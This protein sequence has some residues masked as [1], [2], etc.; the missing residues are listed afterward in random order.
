[1]RMGR[2]GTTIEQ[3]VIASEARQSSSVRWFW[4][5]R[6]RQP[7]NWIAASQ[8]PRNELCFKSS[9]FG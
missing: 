1:M 6:L 4:H 9:K 8:A 5:L 3:A 7:S 2:M